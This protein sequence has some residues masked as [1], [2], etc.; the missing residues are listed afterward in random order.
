MLQSGKYL[1][2]NGIHIKT[3][4]FSVSPNNR[5][6]KYGD[7]LF[8]TISVFKNRILFKQD[9]FNRLKE[10]MMTLGYIIPKNFTPEKLESLIA[11]LLRKNKFFSAARLRI[12]VYR[13]TGGLYTP[14]NNG[15]DYLIEASEAETPLYEQKKDGKKV[16]FYNAMTK[17]ASLISPFKTG[18]ALLYIMASEYRQNKGFDDILILNSEKRVAEAS[19]SNVFVV[20]NN[21]LYTPPVSE[22]CVDGVMRRN[23][24]RLAKENDISV[25]ELPLRIS[26][27]KRSDELFLTNATEG[28]QWVVALEEKR[29]FNKLSKKLSLLLQNKIQD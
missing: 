25:T 29:Y 23:I 3:E 8:E 1:I 22:G 18:N 7:S 27:V 16:C 12:Q 15:F 14:H 19:A 28:I 5:A 26:D 17:N 13:K 6:F 24:I 2:H 4:N 20:K 11:E 9:H 21:G 10:G